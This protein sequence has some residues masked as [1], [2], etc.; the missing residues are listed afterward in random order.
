MGRTIS[1]I[2]GVPLRDGS[3]LDGLLEWGDI[4]RK[5]GRAV[6]AGVL[7]YTSRTETEQIYTS[8]AETR[9][10]ISH[11]R[12]NLFWPPTALVSPP[13]RCGKSRHYTDLEPGPDYKY[14]SNLPTLLQP[15]VMSTLVNKFLPNP[16][17]IAVSSPPRPIHSAHPCVTRS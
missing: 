6:M 9:P 3:L 13:F 11:Q 2:L 15:P 16:K 1:L 7:I 10:I 14:S 8:R 17:T 4:T 12:F 5:V